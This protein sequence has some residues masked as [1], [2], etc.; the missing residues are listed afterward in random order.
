MA[1]VQHNIGLYLEQFI[2]STDTVL[3]KLNFIKFA[4]FSQDLSKFD[5]KIREV[6]NRIHQ[7]NSVIYEQN[8]VIFG[9][10]NTRYRW[11]YDT[12]QESLS[13]ATL[14]DMIRTFVVYFAEERKAKQTRYGVYES[15]QD[16][17]RMQSPSTDQKYKSEKNKLFANMEASLKNV[18]KRTVNSIL[19]VIHRINI[20]CVDFEHLSLRVTYDKDQFEKTGIN[21]FDL[22]FPIEINTQNN[23]TRKLSIELYDNKRSKH[24]VKLN[25]VTIDLKAIDYDIP[26]K[27]VLRLAEEIENVAHDNFTTSEVEFT[28]LL[29]SAPMNESNVTKDIIR[30]SRQFIIP[31][32]ENVVYFL[33][34][35]GVTNYLFIH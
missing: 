19:L 6:E 1:E 4:F 26:T 20:Y 2:P 17:K 22:D 7:H 9:L 12:E 11:P 13:Y 33:L 3:D 14:S 34:M 10:V 28:I 25:G 30:E 23:F 31:E 5:N 32:L 35:T 29:V 21:S 16:P 15:K 27:M 8:K 18:Q 24:P